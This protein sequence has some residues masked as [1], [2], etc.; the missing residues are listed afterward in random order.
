MDLLGQTSTLNAEKICEV[1]STL[2]VFFL[3]L[4]LCQSVSVS[5]SVFLSACLSVSSPPPSL[6]LSLSLHS[7]PPP[8]PPPHLPVSSLSGHFCP[9]RKLCRNLAKTLL[10]KS[11]MTC[12]GVSALKSLKT[13][14]NPRG[15]Q[16]S[17]SLPL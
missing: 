2:L 6:S 4:C 14:S 8:P 12:N 13:A 1:R 3:S 5:V 10:S 16:V 7:P 15:G 17:C 11:Y 9:S